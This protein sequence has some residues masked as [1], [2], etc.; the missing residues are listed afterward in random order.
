MRALYAWCSIPIAWDS[1]EI[2][3]FVGFQVDLVDM[4]SAIME[5]MK[6]GA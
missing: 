6:D 5:K 4:P 1:D 3:Y 2:A